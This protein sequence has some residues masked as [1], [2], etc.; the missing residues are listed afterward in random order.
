M[1]IVEVEVRFTDHLPKD[2]HT[3]VLRIPRPM[4]D[5]STVASTT[6]PAASARPLNWLRV[7]CTVVVWLRR[8]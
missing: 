8:S 5:D 2:P 3:I 7:V 6:T 4:I 1:V